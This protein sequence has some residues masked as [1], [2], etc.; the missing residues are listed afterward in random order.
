MCCR[1]GQR[2]ELIY[3]HKSMGKVLFPR[4]IRVGLGLAS[5]CKVIPSLSAPECPHYIFG[6][7]GQR[8][9]HAGA[10]AT[11]TPVT[12]VTI[13]SFD[14]NEQAP[15]SEDSSHPYTYSR[16]LIFFN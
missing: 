4:V 16:L 5:S 14:I 6:V 10:T 1:R 11:V 12:T 9:R 13:F 2:T 15:Q 8:G 7:K 3:V